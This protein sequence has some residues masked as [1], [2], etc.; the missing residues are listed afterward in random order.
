MTSFAHRFALGT[1]ALAS[2]VAISSSDAVFADTFRANA[3]ALLS[4]VAERVVSKLGAETAA[5]AALPP[6][7]R[8]ITV[9]QV[10]ASRAVIR[11]IS[12]L[13]VGISS[14]NGLIVRDDG[15][16]AVSA[17]SDRSWPLARP[18]VGDETGPVPPADAG[19]L[20][21]REPVGQT[22]AGAFRHLGLLPRARVSDSATAGSL[23]G[24][25]FGPRRQAC[26]SW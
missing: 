19:F 12:R 5:A 24:L 22:G 20:W 23:G 1:P 15:E 9:A 4:L 7:P 21:C 2:A 17:G 16:A 8:A 14:V 10:E 3:A 11:V 18:P 26:R 6:R 13:L 25:P